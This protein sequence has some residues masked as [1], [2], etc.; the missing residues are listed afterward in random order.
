MQWS[1]E[2]LV[3][4]IT[5]WGAGVPITRIS[6]KISSAYDVNI[7]RNAVVGKARRLKLPPRGLPPQ[8]AAARAK[9]AAAAVPTEIE[10]DPNDDGCLYLMGDVAPKQ[11]IKVCRRRGN[12]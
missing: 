9:A 3:D 10:A 4:L 12:A 5:Q 11:T 2:M 6:W 8:M 7:S 1:A